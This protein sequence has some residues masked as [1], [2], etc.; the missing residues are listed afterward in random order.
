MKLISVQEAVLFHSIHKP[1]IF[2]IP[3]DTAL[4][5]WVHYHYTTFVS[6]HKPFIEARS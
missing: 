1:G 2:S 5:Y 4:D 6:K 3:N